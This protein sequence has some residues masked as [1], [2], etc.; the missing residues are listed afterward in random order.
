[1]AKTLRYYVDVCLLQ[2]GVSGRFERN[3]RDAGAEIISERKRSSY[4]KC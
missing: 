3:G 4:I 1:M 2:G